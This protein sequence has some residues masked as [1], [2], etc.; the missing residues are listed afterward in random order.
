MGQI[1][2]GAFGG[3]IADAITTQLGK[4]SEIRKKSSKTI[5]ELTYLNSNT[6]WILLRSGVNAPSYRGDNPNSQLSL[7]YTL[8]GGTLTAIGETGFMQKSGVEPFSTDPAYARGS[9]GYRPKPGITSIEVKTKDTWGC[10]MEATVHFSVWSLDDLDKI[11][12]LYFKPGMTALLEWGHSIYVDNS[13]EV[14]TAEIRDMAIPN[15]Y[16][17]NNSQTYEDI[18]KEIQKRREKNYGNYEGIFG[19][20]TNFSYSFKK[21]GGYDCTITLLSRG[22]VLEGITIP[23]AVDSQESRSDPDNVIKSAFH[24]IQTM[25]NKAGKNLV[26]NNSIHDVFYIRTVRYKNKDIK[27]FYVSVNDLLKLVN[28]VDEH[29][30]EYSNLEQLL[31]YVENYSNYIVRPQVLFGTNE[32]YRRY[33]RFAE[34]VSLNPYVTVLPQSGVSIGIDKY[35]KESSKSWNIP[36]IIR[37]FRPGTPINKIGNILVNYGYFVELIDKVVD[38]KA[39]EFRIIEVIKMLLSNIQKSLGNINNFDLSYNHINDTW[40]I[41]DRN[42]INDIDPC[43][44]IS[45]SGLGTTV[46]ELNISS[47]VSPEI[48]NEMSIAATAPSGGGGKTSSDTN[49][50]NWNEGCVNRHVISKET[51]TKKDSS[52]TEETNEIELTPLG[53]WYNR[54]SFVEFMDKLQKLYD[55]FSGES[56]IKRKDGTSIGDA[57]ES[58]YGELQLTAEALY[59][60]YCNRDISRKR[61][62]GS[63][64][65]GIIPVK[66]GMTF[67]G[68]SRLVIG[69]SFMVSPGILPSKYDTWGYIIT[70]ID[71]RVDKS[72]WTTSIQTQYYPIY[73]NVQSD[74]VVNRSP[75]TV[76]MS[77]TL[78]LQKTKATYTLA[79]AREAIGT[80][81]A[82]AGQCAN[83]TG[84]IAALW[85]TGKDVV[86]VGGNADTVAFTAFMTSINYKIV[87]QQVVDMTATELNNYFNKSSA[88]QQEGAVLQYYNLDYG[89]VS[90]GQ[91]HY[92]AC[93][94]VQGRWYSDFKQNNPCVYTADRNRYKWKF[95]IFLPKSKS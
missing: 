23:K 8:A 68:I 85:Q 30:K 58:A 94:R 86:H 76:S 51:G 17:F 55:K 40:S 29:I 22:T 84:R 4:R 28:I 42:C 93:I 14:K 59:A 52:K 27:L 64:Q 61:T 21:S 54:E 2:E 78:S 25:L 65:T 35:G 31:E 63:L 90:G 87:D 26:S 73:T 88:A 80:L 72:G 38:D 70:G 15:D 13:G 95:V 34:E 60:K 75:N 91:R 89:S 33:V 6:P 66:V 67:D 74:N 81:Q 92:H 20:I 57:A 71:N 19:Y 7:L 53:I 18:D 16:F 32:D 82:T 1:P 9:M 83:F 62:A 24:Q 36:D 77:D 39:E 43:P 48:I 46:R 50:I 45:I 44:S 10:I 69:T 3:R 5:R 56:R 47:E 41:V 79:E 11:D 49:M 37:E 12:K